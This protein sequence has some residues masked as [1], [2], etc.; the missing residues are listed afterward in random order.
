MRALKP[1][2]SSHGRAACSVAANGEIFR[3]VAGLHAKR[4]PSIDAATKSGSTMS[5]S[6]RCCAA[7][8]SIAAI[9]T[10]PTGSAPYA[11][12]A[13]AALAAASSGAAYAAQAIATGGIAA[14]SSIAD[15]TTV[16][17][18]GRAFSADAPADAGATCSAASNSSSAAS[19]GAAYT[20]D[21]TVACCN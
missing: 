7:A 1:T 9:G 3:D 15:D 18:I 6:V 19:S 17:Q 10:R 5:L 12:S 20:T 8:A 13:V 14:T 4:A 2:P 16:H 21:A 11:L